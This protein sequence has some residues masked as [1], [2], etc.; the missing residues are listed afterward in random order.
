MKRTII[1][2][3]L[4]PFMLSL[5]FGCTTKETHRTDISADM[6]SIFYGASSYAFFTSDDGSD[7]VIIS[8]LVDYYNEIKIEPINAKMDVETMYHIGFSKQGK[9]VGSMSIDKKGVIWIGEGSKTY[10]QTDGT[11]N[12]DRIAEIY[13]GKKKSS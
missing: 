8:E 2:L 5:L 4:V 9:S 3:L 7:Q 11:V 1:F 10:Q 13:H 6:I 12:Y